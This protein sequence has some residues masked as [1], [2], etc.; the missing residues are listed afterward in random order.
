MTDRLG[1]ALLAAVLLALAP[2]VSA[3]ATFQNPVRID[4]ADPWMVHH[5]GRYVLVYSMN[6]RLAVICS[7]SVAGLRDTE[8][9]TVW[10]RDSGPQAPCCHMWAPEIHFIDGR[11]YLYYSASDGNYDNLRNYVLES[12]GADPLGPYTFKGRVFP[13]GQDYKTLDGSVHRQPD[14]SLLYLWSCYPPGQTEGQSICIAPMS[15]PWTVS[16][17][18]TKISVG[19]SEEGSAVREGP[20][21]LSRNGTLNLVYSVS[22]G[23]TPSGSARAP[24]MPNS[25]T[26]R[27]PR[28]ADPARSGGDSA[29]PERGAGRPGPNAAPGAL[30]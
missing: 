8:A 17:I 13:P 20:V 1:R 15:N 22:R 4:A 30:T 9:V 7:P 27:S 26:S 14:G 25:T 12:A 6:S 16:A 5:D 10:T 18:R 2:P 3:G 24:A 11:W 29:R 28:Q 23:P 19:D 21:I